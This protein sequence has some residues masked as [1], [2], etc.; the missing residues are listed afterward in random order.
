MEI[1]RTIRT[2]AEIRSLKNRLSRVEG[3]IRG[4]KKMLES[5]A[6][7]TDIITQI[8]A[9]SAALNSF[10]RELLAAHITACVKKDIKNG[11]AESTEEINSLV[12]QV[13]K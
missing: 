5:N 7:S 11:K 13:I 9:A 8:S 1:K 2:D 12:K 6:Y 4:V 10:N 3:Q